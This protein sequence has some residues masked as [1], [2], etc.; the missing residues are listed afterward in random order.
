MDKMARAKNTL[1][2]AVQVLLFI[3]FEFRMMT[4]A[5]YMPFNTL[6]ISKL[7]A[8]NKINLQLVQF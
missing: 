7:K 3:A 2:M 6:N 5:G 8:K 4:P 1:P